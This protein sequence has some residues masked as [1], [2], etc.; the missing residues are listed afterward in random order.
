[1]TPGVSTW[2]FNGLL[3][4]DLAVVADGGAPLLPDQKESLRVFFAD[5]VN[6]LLDSEIGAVELWNSEAL[7]D[8]QIFGQ[9]G[10]LAGAGKISSLHA[11][12]G[13]AFDLSSVD[14]EVR[15]NGVE[16]CI[17]SARLL[18]KLGGK[19]LVVHP[20]TALADP[21]QLAERTNQTVKSVAQVADGCAELGIEV[22]VETLAGCTVG[23]SGPEM[24]N[25]IRLV[26]RP[27]VGVC[28]DV[29][30]VFPAEQ[31]IPTVRLLGPMV[32]TLHI[33]DYDGIEEKHWLPGQGTI[34]WKGLIESLREV[35][36]SGAF[37]YE[38][39]FEADGIRE[40]IAV[41]EENFARLMESA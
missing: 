8:E 40:T 36:Y 11:P 27:N 39:R 24:L 31:L 16:A 21:R 19:A 14:E 38:V 1:M 15:M 25:L 37:P 18:A 5:L 3:P 23:S 2:T 10:R 13:A 30:H 35:G 22:A 33:S 9:L 28:I 26:N 32:L 20:S 41:I 6:S 17:E 34:D 12:F 29:N 7:R 4:K